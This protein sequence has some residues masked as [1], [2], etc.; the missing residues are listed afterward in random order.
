MIYRPGREPET[1][2][3]PEILEGEK[4]IQGFRLEMAEFWKEA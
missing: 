4:P 1:L 3:Q 2:F